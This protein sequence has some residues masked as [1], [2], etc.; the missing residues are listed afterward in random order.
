M[1]GIGGSH[2]KHLK[3]KSL[4]LLLILSLSVI[5]VFAGGSKEAEPAVEN[6]SGFDNPVL[7]IA[8][9]GG[10][11]G[12]AY[13]YEI[14]ERFE[15]AYPGVTV[16]MQI[17]PTIGAIITPQIASGNWPDFMCCNGNDTMGL[18][19]T[20]KREKAILDITDVYDGP[21]LDDPS[22]TL[23]DKMMPGLLESNKY[24]P[25]GDGRIY[26]APFN[27]GPT[28][29]VYN[30]TLFEKNGW[31][32]PKTWDDFYALGDEA[33]KQGIS[34]ITYPGIYPYY[35]EHMIIAAITAHAGVDAINA[36]MSYQEGSWNNPE[37][38]E[39]L[40]EFVRM[41]N[42]YV[43]PGS[44]ALNHTQSQSEVMMDHALFISTGNWV[45]SEMADAPRTEG[46]EFAMAPAPTVTEEE[47]SYIRNDGDTFIIPAQAD[48]TELAKEFLRF[49]YT[50]E[51]VKLF[52]EKSNGVYALA[53]ALDLI[54]GIVSDGVYGMY[55]V[56][57]QPG[58]RSVVAVLDAVPT[59]CNVVPNDVIWN[60]V[61]DV[62]AGRLSI[63]DWV[64]QIETAYAEIRTFM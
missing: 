29:L 56:N 5:P 21:A 19:T 39:V 1:I 36:I 11:Y 17:S 23:R 18:I 32:L 22:V 38:I 59:G 35:W 25:Y 31:E 41:A 55:S 34:L 15:E 54:K 9:F 30:K 28:G 46:F 24:A 63:T 14:V 49:L 43:L 47:T 8:V 10:G 4:A 53:D 7:D 6:T 64:N 57:N 60:P 52:A 27:C 3:I 13:W 37:V 42:G 20:M 48:N 62:L 2:M 61:P 12:D 33:A 51:S 45:E 16:N 58:V 50:D 40:E 26:F 44:E